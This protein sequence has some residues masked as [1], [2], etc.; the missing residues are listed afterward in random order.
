M[1][2]LAECVRKLR[3]FP[4]NV[5]NVYLVGDVLVDAASRHAARRI[6]R[7]LD[8]RPLGAHV[9][10]HA[11]PDHQGAT[12][13]V[14]ERRGAPLW[15]GE[16][17]ADALEDGRIAERQPD[18]P[19]NRLSEWAFPG[20]PHPVARRLQEGDAVAGF[21]VLDTPGHSAGHIS[22]W[23]ESDRTLLLGDVAFGCNPLTGVPGLHEPPDFFTP[24][25]PRNRESLRRLGELGPAL[26]LFGHGPPLRDP[27][28]FARFTAALAD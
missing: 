9:V 8:G 21:A 15:A 5:M 23:R 12:H 22:L 3:G 6:L 28:R 27:E 1:R 11:H 25:P 14:C 17:D 7:Q 4:P 16:R 13:A 24:D 18:H 10:T 26:V 2:E 20:P 19:M